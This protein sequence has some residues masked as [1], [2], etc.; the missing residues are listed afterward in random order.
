MSRPSSR[1][2][3]QVLSF[4]LFQSLSFRRSLPASTVRWAE[5][6]VVRC[7]FIRDLDLMFNWLNNKS[8]ERQPD[9]RD[10]LFG[11][12]PLKSFVLVQRGEFLFEVPE[13]GFQLFPPPRVRRGFQI[14]QYP[15]AR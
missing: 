11:D 7:G 2:L 14:A 3:F 9:I 5:Q 1:R 15:L 4:S 8:R 10:T 12:M 13:S 6:F